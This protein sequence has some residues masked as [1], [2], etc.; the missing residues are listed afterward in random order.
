MYRFLRS[1][2]LKLGLVAAILGL[3]VCSGS[4]VRVLGSWGFAIFIAAVSIVLGL[5]AA[6][7]SSTSTSLATRIAKL[8]DRIM[9]GGAETSFFLD[10]LKKKIHSDASLATR[11]SSSTEEIASTT[12]E[13][14]S[15][16]D[17]AAEV[18]ASV[19][20]ESAR[21]RAELA[22]GVEKIRGA[23]ELAVAASDNMAELQQKSKKI[24]VIADVINEIATRTNLVALNAAIEAARAGERGRGFAVVAQ[25]VRHLAQRT[26]SATVEIAAMLREIDEKADRSSRSMQTLADEVNAATSPAERAAALLDK[27]RNLAAESESQVQAITSMTRAHADTTNEMS[28][29]VKTILEGMERSEQEVPIAANAILTLAETAEEIFTAVAPF[30]EDGIHHSMRQ[31]AQDSAKRVSELFEAAVAAGKVRL[32]DLFDRNYRE[33]PNT[34]PP[35]YATAFDGFTDRVLPEIQ[36]PIL[37]AH[38]NVA[39]AGAV[40]DHGYF[41]THNL[42]FSRPLT[43]QYE[44]DLANNR[45]KRIFSDRT[46]SRCGSNRDPFLLQTYKRDTGEVMHDISAPI[47]VFGRHWGGFRI[48]Y[49]TAEQKNVIN[50]PTSVATPRTPGQVAQAA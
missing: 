27:I 33:I 13:I 7:T 45:T 40:D 42:K 48:G 2:W 15:K 24:Q 29:S 12:A 32:E 10:T 18:A 30:C 19:L 21:G 14:A 35:K 49:R 17:R 28:Q 5:L 9:I 41:P 26:K 8:V 6:P 50:N 22:S 3:L 36:E 1:L 46:G 39:Y 23:R 43:G 11:I 4:L 47:F 25:E 37:R 16:A 34:N 20:H 38:S 31:V 44:V